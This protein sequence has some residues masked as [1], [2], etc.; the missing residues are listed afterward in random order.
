[1]SLILCNKVLSTDHGTGKFSLN[2]SRSA[3]STGYAE[4]RLYSNVTS[5]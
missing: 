1:M 2:A 4:L 3:G 5:S